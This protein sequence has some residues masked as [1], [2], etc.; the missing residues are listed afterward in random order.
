MQNKSERKKKL[1]FQR[2]FLLHQ[3][4]EIGRQEDRLL[5]ANILLDARKE[6]LILRQEILEKL[7]RKVTEEIEFP[8]QRVDKP[9]KGIATPVILS[10]N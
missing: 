7:I 2:Q 4:R 8:T 10:L 3:I 1:E 9:I 5:L 6:E